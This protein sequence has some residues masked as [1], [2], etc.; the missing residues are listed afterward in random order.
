MSNRSIELLQALIRNQCVNDGTVN[1]G[2]ESKNAN[3][4]EALFSSNNVEIEKISKVEN[5]D[6]LI[7]RIP[8]SDPDAPTLLLLGHTDVVPAKSQD[9][10]FD[11][12][13]GELVDGFIQGRGAVDMLNLTSTMAVA[14]SRIIEEGYNL[15]GTVIFA[16]VADEEAGGKYGA[17]FLVNEYPDLVKADYVLTESGGIQMSSG[18][19]TFLPVMVGEK[20]VHWLNLTTTG[21]PTHGS[22]P[23]GSNNA[24]KTMSS[25]VERI[26]RYRSPSDFTDGWNDF[27]KALGFRDELILKLSDPS[28]LDEGLE[29]LEPNL[30]SVI[31]ACCHNTISP[32][33]ISGGTKV[34]TVADECVLGIDIRSM[35][36][37]QNS[38]VEAMLKDILADDFENVSIEFTQHDP[39]TISPTQT[40]LW[41]SLHKISNDLIG[42]SEL[43]PTIAPFG[44]DARFFR[45]NNSVAYG[46][47]L[48]SPEIKF[49]QHLSMFH[50]R[51]EKVDVESI[52][53]TEEMFYR[54]ILDICM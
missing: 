4:I 1:S 22:K 11:P 15:K 49:E 31:H 54:V 26:K 46:F 41:Q 8:G 53:L 39:G 36:M 13:G 32:N 27:L 34:N 25:I 37:Q 9:W 7:V 3:T 12:F 33:T 42:A 17:E 47:G 10:D 6:N 18:D 16:A 2:N 29:N 23:Y 5:R 45:R 20:G 24:I 30:A 48:F 14:L 44:T 50:G 38:D 43:V 19:K 28:T 40:S 35:P 51:N 52:K 21:V